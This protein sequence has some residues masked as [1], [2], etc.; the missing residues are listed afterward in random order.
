VTAPTTY[1]FDAA[2]Q[3]KIAALALRDAAF[4]RQTE[5]L[6]K[7]EYLEDDA[8][9]TLVDIVNTYYSEYRAAPS[10]AVVAKI[11]KERIKSKAIRADM[12]SELAKAIRDL[13]S[14]DLSDRDYV[15]DE[16]AR[17]ARHQAIGR[18]IYNSVD[19][20]EDKK[21]EEIGDIIKK[22]V[23]VGAVK[24]GGGY[25]FFK[26][27]DSRTKRRVDVT[28]GLIKPD[29]ITTGFHA[30]DD[31]L[32]H[33]GWGRKELT[34]LMGAAKSGKTTALCEYAV[35]ATLA[36]FNVLYVTLEVSRDI[37]AERLDTNISEVDMRELAAKF[38]EVKDKLSVLKDKAGRLELREYPTGSMK[39]SDLRRL[40]AKYASEGILFD[41]IVVDYADIMAPEIRSGAP[42]EDSKSVYVDL[43]GIAFEPTAP[44]GKS[45]AILTATQTN[46]EGAKATVA[47]MTDVADDFNK[48]RIAD[49]VISI[50]STEEEKT[51]GEARLFF[52]ASRNQAGNFTLRIKQDL[53][54]MKFLVKILGRE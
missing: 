10:L 11:V 12:G 30:F 4:I 34:V 2:F 48:V 6:V 33:K 44:G 22:A 18:A 52:A 25:D 46:R 49:L 9:A 37:L 15:V 29:G 51:L 8:A 5:G 24:D 47:R 38:H 13:N 17:F 39:P 32:Y 3:R 7:P 42:I 36:G 19:L 20:L 26:E 35:R 31:V 53:N 28:K 43:R 50:N 27:I 1:D 21:F 45:P 16:V 41:L 40:I 14:E 23:D 54:R